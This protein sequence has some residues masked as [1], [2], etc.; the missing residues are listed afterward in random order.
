MKRERKKE[1]REGGRKK[2]RKNERKKQSF[3]LNHEASKAFLSHPME[4]K[5]RKI[6]R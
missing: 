3:D 1:K 4:K 5:E 6:D 2:E